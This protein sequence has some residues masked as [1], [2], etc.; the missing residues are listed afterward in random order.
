MTVYI[1]S[2]KN[3][4]KTRGTNKKVKQGRQIQEQLRKINCILKQ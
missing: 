4:G 3:Q 1:A 2:Q